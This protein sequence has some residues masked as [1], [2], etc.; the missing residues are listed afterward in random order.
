M[1]VAAPEFY[2]R[3]KLRIISPK[4]ILING[5]HNLSLL[6]DIIYLLVI[7]IIIIFF[8]LFIFFVIKSYKEIASKIKI[9]KL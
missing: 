6:L 9:N 3:F 1:F 8:F 4:K 2:E 5:N 7:F